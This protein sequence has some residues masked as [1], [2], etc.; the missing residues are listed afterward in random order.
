MKDPQDTYFA[1]FLAYAPDQLISD[2]RPELLI[3]REEP[4][5]PRLIPSRFA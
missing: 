4:P 3:A 2:S 1:R 5:L